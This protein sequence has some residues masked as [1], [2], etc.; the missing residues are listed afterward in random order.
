[1][2]VWFIRLSLC[3]HHLLKTGRFAP[4]FSSSARL[5]VP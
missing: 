3:C 4:V 2:V 1:M 5:S